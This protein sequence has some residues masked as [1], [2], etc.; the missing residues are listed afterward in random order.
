MVAL[1]K[2]LRIKRSA[3]VLQMEHYTSQD[4]IE[5]SR[6]LLEE[7]LAGFK[8]SV[9]AKEQKRQR[10]LYL[11]FQNGVGPDIKQQKQIQY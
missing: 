4:F 3:E 1:F 9:N 6:R 10:Q 5:I 8:V 11:N 7:T 2:E